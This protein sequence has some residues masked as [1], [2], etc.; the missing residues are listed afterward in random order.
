M[1]RVAIVGRGRVGGAL[2][3][4]L[5]ADPAFELTPPV[6]RDTDITDIA[7]DADIVLLAVTDGAVASVASTIIPRDDTLFV[8]FAGSLTLDVLQ[9]HRR[10]ARRVGRRRAPGR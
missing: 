7:A 4:N 8:H 1:T 3:A 2:A 6:G 9:P 5:A 10:R